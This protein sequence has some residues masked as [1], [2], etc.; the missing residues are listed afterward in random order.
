MQLT[1]HNLYHI[2]GTYPILVT[3]CHASIPEHM[4]K[5]SLKK[6]LLVGFQASFSKYTFLICYR[7]NKI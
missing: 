6:V 4:Q 7:I 3:Y 5:A 1:K 2:Q